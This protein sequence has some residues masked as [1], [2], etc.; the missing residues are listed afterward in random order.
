MNLPWTSRSALRA[1]NTAA[2]TAQI[3]QQQAEI[4]A[5]AADARLADYMEVSRLRA[6]IDET[7]R[8]ALREDVKL[9]LDRIV[10]LSGQ[11][12]IFHPAPAPPLAPEPVPSTGPAPKTRKTFAEVKA[13]ARA[14][15]DKGEL[16]LG[17]K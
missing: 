10:Q 13:E 7:E 1:A 15:I 3:A 11:P 6:S 5:T 9:L 17:A 8:Q 12:P 4:R 16:S 2:E 14:A